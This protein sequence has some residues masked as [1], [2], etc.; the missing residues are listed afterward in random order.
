[1]TRT[2]PRL[3]IGVDLGGTKIHAAV[4]DSEGTVLGS[5][6]LGTDV[7]GGPSKVVEDIAYVVRT[8]LGANLS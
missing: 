7:E 2:P 6:R 4:V 1:M 3:A 5:H 8:G